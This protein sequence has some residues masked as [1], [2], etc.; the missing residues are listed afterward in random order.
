LK[1]GTHCTIE[2][3]EA[4]LN[5]FIEIK[6]FPLFDKDHKIIKVVD[7]MRDIT[8]RKRIEERLLALSITDEL[9]GLYNRRGFF[10]LAAQQLKIARRQ[11]KGIF[12]LSADLDDLKGINDRYGHNMGDRAL[13]KAANI[14]KDSF[15]ESDI[16]SRIGGD[17]F[18]VL[19]I[20]DTAT[21]SELLAS[22]LQNNL[23]IYN[24]KKADGYDLSLSIGVAYCEPESTCSLDELMTLSDKLMYKQK[25]Q[26][27]SQL[28]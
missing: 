20:V 9:T 24:A 19:Q 6:A 22:R 4:N 13:I 23:Q 7:V 21:T 11:R 12:V 28:V 5:K 18:V 25:S 2:K 27:R 16:I 3:F 14:L 10:T 15:R 8:E 1:T 26:K 17:E